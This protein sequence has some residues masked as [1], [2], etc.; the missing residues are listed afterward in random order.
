MKYIKPTVNL[1]SV[2]ANAASTVSCTSFLTPEDKELIDSILGGQLDLA[3][4]SGEGCAFEFEAYCK[5]TS[6]GG[7]VFHS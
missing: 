6:T 2:A 5:F 7:Q 3:F 1:A 4:G